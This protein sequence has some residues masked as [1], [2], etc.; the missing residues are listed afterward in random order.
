ME[1]YEYEVLLGF[2]RLLEDC[3]GI[4]VEA[5]IYP[6]YRNTKLLGEIAA[7]LRQ[8]GFMLR[9]FDP[10]DSFDRDV[11]VGNAYFTASRS[12]LDRLDRPQRDKFDL[13]I[14]IWNI[15]PYPS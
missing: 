7:Y 10:I 12:R 14:D 8:F 13:L 5:W 6:V 2:G 1:G 15:P 9:R 3:I 11:V 4:E